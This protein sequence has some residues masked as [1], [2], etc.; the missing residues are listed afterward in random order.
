M[1]AYNPAAIALPVLMHRLFPSHAD[2]K[3]EQQSEGSTWTNRTTLKAEMLHR[4]LNLLPLQSI[5]SL[6]RTL[7]LN[8]HLCVPHL[9]CFGVNMSRC[10]NDLA[11]QIYYSSSSTSS[12]AASHNLLSTNK[13]NLHPHV[14][15]CL[16]PRR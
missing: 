2:D 16:H 12:G 15:L 6:N 9:H 3:A 13:T 7:I 5:C 8:S 11:F 10:L 4:I 1:I 14:S